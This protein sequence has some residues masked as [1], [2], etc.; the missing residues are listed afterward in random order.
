MILRK[1]VSQTINRAA[2]A[3]EK[4]SENKYVSASVIDSQMDQL[5]LEMYKLKSEHDSLIAEAELAQNAADAL[6][7]TMSGA[8]T[9]DSLNG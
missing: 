1:S 6:R 8:V 9:G 2:D 5:K 7:L 3:L 4:Q